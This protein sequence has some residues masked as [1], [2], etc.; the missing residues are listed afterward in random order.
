M[1]A[2]ML[3]MRQ[4][5]ALGLTWSEVHLDQRAA[6]VRQALQYR[7]GDGLQ[8][9]PAEDRTVSAESPPT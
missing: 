6:Y 3:G 4:G 9:C 1:L 8:S 5:E 2:V 7:P